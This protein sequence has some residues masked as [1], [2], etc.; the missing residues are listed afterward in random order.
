MGIKDILN[1]RKERQPDNP[2]SR[3]RVLHRNHFLACEQFTT[4]IEEKGH[5]SN[6]NN[7]NS[8]KSNTSILIRKHQLILG[9]AAMKVMQILQNSFQLSTSTIRKLARRLLRNSNKKKDA[10]S[11]YYDQ[12]SIYLKTTN[13]EHNKSTRRFTNRKKS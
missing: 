3:V 7:N 10:L 1:K 13:F 11:N 8:I 12:E 6:Y 5:K 9:T 2:R 4:F